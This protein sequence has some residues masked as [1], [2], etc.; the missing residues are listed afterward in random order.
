MLVDHPEVGREMAL[1]HGA[2]FTHEGAEIIFTELAEKIDEF[3]NQNGTAC[4][5]LFRR[6]DPGIGLLLRT[7]E[8]APVPC[9]KRSSGRAGRNN[10]LGEIPRGRKGP[11]GLRVAA[12]ENR[13]VT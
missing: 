4:G 1:K 10:P 8:D 13:G 7:R 3:A 5:L 12:N 9:A 6:G 2:Y 11:G